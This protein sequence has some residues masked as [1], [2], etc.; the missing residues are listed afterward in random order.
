MISGVFAQ[1]VSAVP[2]KTENDLKARLKV[3]PSRRVIRPAAN[4][5][6]LGPGRASER[7]FVVV[8]EDEFAFLDSD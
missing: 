1:P 3:V 4:S 7:Q 8:V 5:R 6:F 2:M